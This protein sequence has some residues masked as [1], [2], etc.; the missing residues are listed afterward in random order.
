MG[1]RLPYGSVRRRLLPLGLPEMVRERFPN[2]AQRTG[3]AMIVSGAIFALVHF[4]FTLGLGPDPSP[5]L[6]RRVFLGARCA[7]HGVVVMLTVTALL[8]LVF[9]R[10]DGVRLELGLA[11][12]RNFLIGVLLV[13]APSW[14]IHFSL[15]RLIGPSP[16]PVVRERDWGEEGEGE[17]EGEW[18]RRGRR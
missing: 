13:W 8:V 11:Q 2:P 5:S 14:V 6:V 18:E 10:S 16:R 15:L 7:V 9:Q 12:T 3:A 1:E 4:L 17:G